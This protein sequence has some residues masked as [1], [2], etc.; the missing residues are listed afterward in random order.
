[1][2]RRETRLSLCGELSGAERRNL[3]VVAEE[4]ANEYTG[5]TCDTKQP[6]ECRGV[7]VFGNM[8]PTGLFG[9]YTLCLAAACEA[10]LVLHAWHR[11]GHPCPAHERTV[12]FEPV[13]VRCV[14]L[15]FLDFFSRMCAVSEMQVEGGRHGVLLHGL[16]TVTTRLADVNGEWSGVW[17]DGARA[18]AAGMAASEERMRA[19]RTERRSR[20]CD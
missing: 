5:E 15:T 13:G 17:R 1:M 19:G 7:G 18:V 2:C 8:Q 14:F 16:R 3:Q 12:S 20:G 9:D 11:R 10:S 4:S 6:H